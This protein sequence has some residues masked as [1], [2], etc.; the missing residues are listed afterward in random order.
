[1]SDP[2]LDVERLK[3]SQDCLTEAIELSKLQPPDDDAKDLAS[4]GSRGLLAMA[5]SYCDA[6][7]DETDEVDREAMVMMSEETAKRLNRAS[8]ECKARVALAAKKAG[9]QM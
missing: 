1:V 6:G 8:E 3:A 4:S 2:R 9:V 5:D 7:M